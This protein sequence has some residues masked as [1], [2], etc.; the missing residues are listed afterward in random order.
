MKTP[1]ILAFENTSETV[2]RHRTSQRREAGFTLIELLTVIAIIGI[3]AALSFVGIS[4]ARQ[5]AHSSRDIA[6][7]KTIGTANALHMEENRGAVAP[8]HFPPTN[9]LW[10]FQLLRPYLN[11][12]LNNDVEGPAFISPLDPDKG[13]VNVAVFLPVHRRSY[14]INRKTLLGSAGDYRKANISEITA[15]ARTLYAVNYQVSKKNTNWVDASDSAS[16]E[17][18]PS[19]WRSGAKVGV[20]FMDG[21][22]EV[23]QR[24]DIMPGG[25]REDIFKLDQ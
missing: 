5:Q 20:L 10:F 22:V 14:A 2:I 18:I 7:L 13:G 9:E 16:L 25:V 4:R 24:A 6:N 1:L 19:E 3:L 21:H 17:A 8:G 12:P 23:V 15:P 11:Y